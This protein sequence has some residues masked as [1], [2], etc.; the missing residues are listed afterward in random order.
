MKKLVIPCSRLPGELRLAGP[1]AAQAD[2]HVARRVDVPGL[3]EPE[4]RRPVRELDAEDLAA[5][6]GVRVEV[7]EADRPVARGDRADVRLGDRVVAA[8]HDRQQR[9]RRTTWPTSSLDRRVRARRV[10]G[11]HGRVAEV[12]DPQLLEGVDLRLEVRPGR[13]ARRRGSRAARSGRPGGRRR[14]RRSARRRSR[15]R[16]RPARRDPACTARRRR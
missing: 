16:S 3:D 1:V 12:D 4:H 14:G 6:V 15:R 5:G 8:E 7:D 11:Q 13:A 2:L 10:G 9:R